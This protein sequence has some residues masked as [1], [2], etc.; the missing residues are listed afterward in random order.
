[1]SKIPLTTLNSR[2]ERCWT[3]Y[4]LIR[5]RETIAE[6]R[7]EMLN[8]ALRESLTPDKKNPTHYTMS[9]FMSVAIT[10]YGIVVVYGEGVK[11]ITRIS[12]PRPLWAD[13]R[14]IWNKVRLARIGQS[15]PQAQA[16][17]TSQ[18]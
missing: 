1:M 11:V 6:S 7:G 3:Q 16:L 9:D 8:S 10:H 4:G 13:L 17:S 5:I 2:G 14:S 12:D 18:D 15:H